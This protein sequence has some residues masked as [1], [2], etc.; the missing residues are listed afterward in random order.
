MGSD[1]DPMAVLDEQMRVRGV[2]GLRVVDGSSIP[3]VMR[4]ATNAPI[5]MMAEKVSDLIA[6][7]ELPGFAG[8]TKSSMPS[9]ASV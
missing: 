5:I 7:K 3:R 1:D 6:G 2:R 8:K 4:A 9:A